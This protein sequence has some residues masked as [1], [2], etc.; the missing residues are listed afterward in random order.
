MNASK[1][2]GLIIS[3]SFLS[4]LVSLTV[5]I[6]LLSLL[7]MTGCILLAVLVLYQHMGELCDIPEDHPKRKVL[8]AATLFNV[9][10]LV[11]CVLCA[12]L[13]KTGIF[14]LAEDG[15]KYF[16]ATILSA[17]ILFGGNISPKLPFNRYTGL[18]LP[19]TVTDEDA[20]IVAHRILGY[21]SIP[22]ALVYLAGVPVVKNFEA[23]SLIIILL[24]IGIP[25]G[26]SYW[27][28]RRKRKGKI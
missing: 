25:G 19:W 21:L 3:L 26:L 28:Y 6:P 1:A 4:L 8:K 7:L 20:W 15:E 10:L 16:A 27:F 22:L 14:N 17:V 13:I 9:M 18:R 5:K 12:I 23:L 2:R 24:W 11:V